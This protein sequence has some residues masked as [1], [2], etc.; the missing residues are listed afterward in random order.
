MPLAAACLAA[1]S[2][3][4]FSVAK[5]N[6]NLTFE[7]ILHADEQPLQRPTMRG[8]GFLDLARAEL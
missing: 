7:L 1:S 8:D 2:A 4:D 6:R 5:D 3:V